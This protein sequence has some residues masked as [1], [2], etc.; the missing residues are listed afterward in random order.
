MFAVFSRL[1]LKRLKRKGLLVGK[2]LN[3]QNDVSID[4][5]HCHL[6]KI[7]DNVTIAPRVIILA[8]DAST[9]KI[10]DYTKIGNVTIGDFTFIGA[11]SIIMPNVNI[12]RNVII[13]AGSVVT[14]DIPDY[15][16]VAGNPARVIMSYEEYKAKNV[17]KLKKSIIYDEKFHS[18]NLNEEQKKNMRKE[19]EGKIAF[20]K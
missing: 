13:G 16:V 8:H 3:I 1:Q 5:S 4:V 19:I 10:F 2:N 15:S 18:K 9:K 20:I 14:K 12:G 11:A 6:I 7:G 17:K